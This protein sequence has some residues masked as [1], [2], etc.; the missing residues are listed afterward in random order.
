MSIQTVNTEVAI[1]LLHKDQPKLVF[2]RTDYDDAYKP[3]LKW[4]AKGQGYP[5]LVKVAIEG[6]YEGKCQFKRDLESEGYFVKPGVTAWNSTYEFVPER[7]P[8]HVWSQ[9]ATG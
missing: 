2:W 4:Y 5:T 7:I 8:M 3:E 6:G 1:N 9:I